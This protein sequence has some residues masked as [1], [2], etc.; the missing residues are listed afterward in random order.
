MSHINTNGELVSDTPSFEKLMALF[1]TFP[2]LPSPQVKKSLHGLFR[3]Y[4]VRGVVDVTCVREPQAAWQENGKL[5]P[6]FAYALGCAYGKLL[7]QELGV[8]ASPQVAV[9]YDA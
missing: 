6:F 1:S 4:D 7:H 5:T 8:I 2:A 9:G 3:Q